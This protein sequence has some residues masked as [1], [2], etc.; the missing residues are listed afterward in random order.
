VAAIGNA[1]TVDRAARKDLA[2]NPGGVMQ[3]LSTLI[4]KGLHDLKR[5]RTDRAIGMLTTIHDGMR[6]HVEH[7]NKEMVVLLLFSII[8]IMH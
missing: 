6:S 2:L 3:R 7:S 1:S 5:G 8:G 4:D